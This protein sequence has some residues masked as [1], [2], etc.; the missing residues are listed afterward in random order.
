M[1]RECFYLHLF[2]RHPVVGH[3]FTPPL[4]ERRCCAYLIQ[5]HHTRIPAFKIRKEDNPVIASNMR[6]DEEARILMIGDPS[7][8]VPVSWVLRGLEL[9]PWL[10]WSCKRGKFESPGLRRSLK[11]WLSLR[12]SIYIQRNNVDASSPEPLVG[13][14][15]GEM[16]DTGLL[17]PFHRA[18]VAVI[19]EGK[20][21]CMTKSRVG[22]LECDWRWVGRSL[23]ELF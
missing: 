15:F 3:L 8:C 4:G 19:I 17:E 1:L 21:G 20:D 12:P 22:C 7:V 18:L 9:F 13:E 5:T 23:P 14:E 16:A 11:T 2:I 6:L 10:I